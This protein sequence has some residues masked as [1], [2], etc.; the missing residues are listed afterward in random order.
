MDKFEINRDE[1]LNKVYDLEKCKK[2]IR[3]GRYYDPFQY[4]MERI[5]SIDRMIT[6]IQGYQLY[7][8]HISE[9]K[10]QKDDKKD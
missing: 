5:V 4:A 3:E 10:E 7:L 1:V 6:E 8:A 2:I 9:K